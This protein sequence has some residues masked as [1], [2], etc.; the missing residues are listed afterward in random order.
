MRTGLALLLLLAL[1]LPARAADWG[2]IVPGTSRQT[3]VRNLYG[4][5]TENRSQKVDGYDSVRWLYDGPRAPGGIQQMTVDFGL[6]IGGRY[7]PDVVRAVTLVPKPGVFNVDIV[8][9]GWGRPDRESPAGQPIAF[10]YDSGV[11]IY[12][13]DDG[14]TVTSLVFTPPQSPR[15]SEPQGGRRP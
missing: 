11:L 1:A 12:F 9:E 7:R 6:L 2:G 5:P 10:F 14:R 8:L 15:S 13:A 4:A 3:D